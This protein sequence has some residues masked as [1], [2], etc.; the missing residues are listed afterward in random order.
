[1]KLRGDRRGEDAIVVVVPGERIDGSSSL[2][3]FQGDAILGSEGHQRRRVA[4][5]VEAIAE[6]RWRCIVVAVVEGEFRGEQ[7]APVEVVGM[8]DGRR[9]ALVD[10]RVGAEITAAAAATS[11]PKGGSPRL[12]ID[13]SVLSSLDAENQNEIL[14]SL[15]AQSRRFVRLNG[16]MPRGRYEGKRLQS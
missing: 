9:C 7:E 3:G 10:E 16:R 5:A 1:M 12:G 4:G 13:G 15:K 11:R 14:V 8:S 6:D 2:N